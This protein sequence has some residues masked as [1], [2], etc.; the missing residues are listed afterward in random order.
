VKGATE[1]LP[2]PSSKTFSPRY[3]LQTV[4]GG[5]EEN[6]P[7]TSM[8]QGGLG[9]VTP[10]CDPMLRLRHNPPCCSLVEVPRQVTQI[11]RVLVSSGPGVVE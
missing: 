11:R 6:K 9:N 5:L 8:A 1:A 2:S 7:G 10:V 3:R 4:N